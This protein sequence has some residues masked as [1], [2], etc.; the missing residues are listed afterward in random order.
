MRYFAQ[1]LLTN[2][3]SNYA[4]HFTTYAERKILENLS[5]REIQSLYLSRS[6]LFLSENKLHIPEQVFKYF[7][8]VYVH[9]FV[10]LMI[11]LCA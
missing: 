3:N 11:G 1:I 10:M 4:N 8:S 9:I 7:S 2:F 5:V 6:N